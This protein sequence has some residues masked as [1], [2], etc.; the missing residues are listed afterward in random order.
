MTRKPKRSVADAGVPPDP[1][2]VAVAVVVEE[3]G[4]G[5]VVVVVVASAPWGNGG[6]DMAA[7]ERMPLCGGNRG[8]RALPEHRPSKS[9]F[10]SRN[11]EI[12]IQ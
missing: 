5:L 8:T 11:G 12:N 10:R 2:D 1:V 4:L 9:R 7:W 3:V 6:G